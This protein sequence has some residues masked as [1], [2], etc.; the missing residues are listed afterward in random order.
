M[1]CREQHLEV[2]LEHRVQVEGVAGSGVAACARNSFHQVGP[3]RRGSMPPSE[4]PVSGS[5]DVLAIHSVTANSPCPCAEATPDGR[6]HRRRTEISVAQDLSSVSSWTTT[7]LVLY[8]PITRMEVLSAG[9]S[10]DRS[11]GRHS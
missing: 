8:W 1:P 11:P 2:A 3:D 5:G 7:V 6:R 4:S 9:R 10:A